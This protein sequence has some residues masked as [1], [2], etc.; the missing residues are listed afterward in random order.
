VPFFAGLADD[1]GAVPGAVF[2][3]HSGLPEQST[4][5]R[6]Q[7]FVNL[8]EARQAIFLFMCLP[9]TWLKGVAFS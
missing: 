7:Q 5:Q 9:F 4:V 3:A 8:L 2:I 6:W 1:A